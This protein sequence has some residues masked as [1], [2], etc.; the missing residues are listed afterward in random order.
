MWLTLR[1]W[2]S[3]K[4]TLDYVV[5]GFVLAM[6][7]AMIVHLFGVQSSEALRAIK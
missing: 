5:M 4:V 7:V 1:Q 3:R 6:L 2:I